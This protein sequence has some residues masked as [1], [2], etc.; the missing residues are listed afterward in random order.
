MQTGILDSGNNY[1]SQDKV[2]MSS[3]NATDNLLI[4]VKNS[5]HKQNHIQNKENR[6]TKTRKEPP[7]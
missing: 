5:K 1:N 3:V 6:D 2:N 4:P 7:H